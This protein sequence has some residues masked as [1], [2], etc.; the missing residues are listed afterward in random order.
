[1][2]RLLPVFILL[3]CSCAREYTYTCTCIN[4]TGEEIDK[5]TITA[6]SLTDAEPTCNKKELQ[7]RAAGSYYSKAHCTLYK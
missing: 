6:E 3:F 2:K 1:M 4:S 7:W 5:I